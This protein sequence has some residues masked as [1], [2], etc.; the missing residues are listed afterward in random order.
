MNSNSSESLEYKSANDI[1]VTCKRVCGERVETV[2]GVDGA[3]VHVTEEMDGGE[4][5]LQDRRRESVGEEKRKVV[6]Q[7]KLP[8][9]GLLVN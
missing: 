4:E 8:V 1:S 9:L 7:R 2:V 5:E 6:H 3:I